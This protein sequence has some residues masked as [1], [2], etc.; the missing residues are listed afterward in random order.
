MGVG[1]KIGVERYFVGGNRATPLKIKARSLSKP[2][3]FKIIYIYIYTRKLQEI[4]R[5]FIDLLF[6]ATSLFLIILVI[7]GLELPKLP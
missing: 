6:L 1:R 3:G 7:F 2:Y 4:I 5:K